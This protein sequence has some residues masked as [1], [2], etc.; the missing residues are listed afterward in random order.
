MNFAPPSVIQSYCVIIHLIFLIK[1]I[2]FYQK[3]SRVRRDLNSEL[4]VFKQNPIMLPLHHEHI[5]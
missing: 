5:G 3:N 2:Q 1:V 4:L